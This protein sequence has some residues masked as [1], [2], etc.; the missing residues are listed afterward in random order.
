MKM[1][2]DVYDGELPKIIYVNDYSDDHNILSPH[3]YDMAIEIYDPISNIIYETYRPKYD[4]ASISVTSYQLEEK[5]GNQLPTTYELMV[6]VD[7]KYHVLDTYKTTDG[8]FKITNLK[9]GETY[10]I[11]AKD[12]S[13]TYKSQMVEVTPTSVDLEVPIVFLMIHNS[14]DN[15]G[16]NITFFIKNIVDV[17]PYLY[18]DDEPRLIIKR[19]K[20]GSYTIYGT[21]KNRNLTLHIDHYK[22]ESLVNDVIEIEIEG[23]TTPLRTV[24]NIYY[25]APYRILKQL[26]PDIDS[27]LTQN[28]NYS[29]IMVQSKNNADRNLENTLYISSGVESYTKDVAY[30]FSTTFIIDG[31]VD[32]IQNTFKIKGLDGL[33]NN[34]STIIVGGERMLLESYSNVTNIVQVKRGIDATLPLNHVDDTLVYV[35]SLN[36][37]SVDY[38]DD[39]VVV[40]HSTRTFSNESVVSTIDDVTV[41]LVGLAN[42]PYP[43]I[44]V[45]YGGEYWNPIVDVATI[46][47]GQGGNDGIYGFYQDHSV[48]ISDRQTTLI[49]SY[50]DRNDTL[51]D[52][53]TVDVTGVY[54]YT[55]AT[56]TDAK[57][58]EV[59]LYNTV[60]GIE[61][62]RVI[63]S[64]TTTS[65]FSEPYNLIGEF[66]ND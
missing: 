15:I 18:I 41:D 45:K 27:V 37:C 57:R 43:P 54:T 39:S 23:N 46:T 4:Y 44:N 66:K 3:E 24:D 49:Y 51:I 25:E 30:D 36:V 7:D 19:N 31:G 12:D 6:K 13:N 61:S 9:V 8:V 62:D 56:N 60:N 11:Q 20:N 52:T 47:F 50:Y 5:D 53:Y 22:N 16:L 28:P 10:Y 33:L 63:H 55:I 2:F 14:I 64:F 38:S 34:G 48:T 1:T 21:P 32:R 42:K 17:E 40:N 58:I 35:E 65:Y 26:N 29:R 59:V